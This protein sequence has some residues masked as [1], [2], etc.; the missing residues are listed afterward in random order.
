MTVSLPL[1]RKRISTDAWPESSS[2]GEPVPTISPDAQ[3]GDAVG[4]PL[5]LLHVVRREQDA[6]AQGAEVADR[7]PGLPPR[8]RVEA[9]RRLV[10]EDELGVADEREG[11]IEP[12]QLTAGERA[13]P[14]VA[15][16]GQAD[17]VD[18]LVGAAVA[19]GSSP[20]RARRSP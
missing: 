19:R 10:E 16:L 20:R 1:R 14:R 12:A 5:R 8:G 11:E 9:G 6:L 17:E 13:H 3:D 2:C 18:H 15:L 7:V 4:E